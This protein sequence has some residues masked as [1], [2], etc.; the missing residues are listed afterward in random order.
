MP[1][2]GGFDKGAQAFVGEFKIKVFGI[3][4]IDPV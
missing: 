4:F 3:K 1:G 2:G